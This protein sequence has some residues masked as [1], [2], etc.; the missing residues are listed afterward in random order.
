MTDTER[1]KLWKQYSKNKDLETR[2]KIIVEYAQLVKVVAGRLL[3]YFANNIEYDDLV[4]FGTIGLI[5]AINRYDITMKTKF[6]SYASLRIRGEI[7]DQVRKMD[8]IP[9]TV[10]LKEKQVKQVESKLRAEL[11]RK[12][13]DKEMMEALGMSD[14]EYYATMNDIA[15]TKLVYIDAVGSESESDDVT[16]I[17]DII[18]QSTFEQPGD[19]ILKEELSQKLSKA[20]QKLTD[21]EKE[22]IE[23]YYYEELT[24]K[25][26]ANILGVSDSRV[27]QLHI[28][29]VSK[30]REYLG[31]YMDIIYSNV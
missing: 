23:L 14:D 15:G 9:R 1:E 19:S 20:I 5:D 22:V 25:E 13:S 21:R 12:P 24:V 4:S 11:E 8:W 27:S 26:I 31:S 28:R 10:R 2:N 6:E 7:L 16:P 30:L 17:Y 29:A 3:A 18:E